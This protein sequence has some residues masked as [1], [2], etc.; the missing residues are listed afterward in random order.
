MRRMTFGLA[1]LTS[2]LHG[3]AEETEQPQGDEVA[4]SARLAT[5]EL[6]NGN[7]LTLTELT[8]DGEI[9]VSETTPAGNGERF[10]IDDFPD[11]SPLELFARLTPEGTDVPAHLVESATAEERAAWMGG[12]QSTREAGPAR[13]RIS[14]E[15]LGWQPIAHVG[16][17]SCDPQ[18]G[19]QYF[20]D[21]HCNTF[22][23]YGYG[24]SAEACS[25][26]MGFTGWQHTSVGDMRHTYT[27]TA[28][29]EGTGRIRHWRLD[30]DDWVNVL[31]EIIPPDSVAHYYS[32]RKTNPTNR[33]TRAEPLDPF[34]TDAYV[35]L[36][37]R[38]FSQV[39]ANAP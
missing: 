36:W 25:Y 4:A 24:V 17:G 15:E 29:C 14:V 2:A 23:P 6:S 28:A 1:V 11:A 20:Q 10:L 19:W 37:T 27:R 16:G 39:V 38:F 9:V 12:R 26:A 35:R 13:F 33:R 22:G 7:R 31:D 3:C 8:S 5:F 32:Y 30:G 34:D 18:T 21:N